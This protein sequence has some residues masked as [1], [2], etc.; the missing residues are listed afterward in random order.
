M[1]WY[2]GKYI[3]NYYGRVTVN[4][5]LSGYNYPFI[6]CFCS[7]ATIPNCSICKRGL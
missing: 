5:V 6:L 4:Y 2:A 7:S 3:I 1:N